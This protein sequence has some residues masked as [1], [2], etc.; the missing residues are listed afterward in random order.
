MIIFAY[1]TLLM[2]VGGIAGCLI[3]WLLTR[4]DTQKELNNMKITTQY[5]VLQPNTVNGYQIEIINIYSSFDKRDIDALEENLKKTVGYC[6]VQE[7][8]TEMKTE[9]KTENTNEN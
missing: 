4:N 6:S 9:I 7:I 5:R 2:S 3:Y 1:W 8:K